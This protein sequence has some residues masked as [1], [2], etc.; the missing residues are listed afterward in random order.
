MESELDTLRRANAELQAWVRD[1]LEE[2]R[3]L[4]SQVADPG[5]HSALPAVYAYPMVAKYDGKGSVDDASSFVPVKPS[6]AA[7]VVWFG[8]GG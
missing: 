7:P 6:P 4:R 1:L 2:N 3:Y 5:L 8:S